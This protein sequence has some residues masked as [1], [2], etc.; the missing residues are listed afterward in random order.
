M[1]IQSFPLLHQPPRTLGGILQL[2][3]E[4]FHLTRLHLDV[5][6]YL[7]G[8]VVLAYLLGAADG[9]LEDVCVFCGVMMS[10]LEK[11]KQINLTVGLI[12]GSWW[13]PSGGC[14]SLWFCCVM[15]ELGFD[16]VAR[17]RAER[18]SRRENRWRRR[19]SK[20]FVDC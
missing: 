1:L 8:R 7:L 4:P 2:L 10:K 14:L 15:L 9:L 18:E 19:R 3:P 5:H 6:H 16:V 12:V 11:N 20:M 13:K 17:A